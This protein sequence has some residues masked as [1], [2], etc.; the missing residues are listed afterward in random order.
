MEIMIVEDEPSIREVLTSLFQAEGWKVHTSSDGKD[1]LLKARNFKLDLII[2]DL[3]IPGIPGEEVCRSIRQDSNVPVI[4]I[5]SKSNESDMVNGLNLGADDY[6]TKPFRVKEVLARI[7]ALKRRINMFSSN[8]NRILWFNKRRLV[9]NFEL[10][11][12][13]V[14]GKPANLTITEFKLFSILV[15][16]PGKVYSRHDLSYEVQG[17]RF[18][19]DGRAMDVHILNIRKKIEE[20]PKNP[21]YIVTKI[22]AGYKFNFFPE[23]GPG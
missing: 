21:E 16:N 7:H 12:V 17:Y 1:A 10:K 2:L 14:D 20:D 9:V 19:G 4:M 3:M 8:N 11:E 6:I 22:G 13:F 18:I 23:E 5:T 15:K